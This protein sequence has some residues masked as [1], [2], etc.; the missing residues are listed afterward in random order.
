MGG[1]FMLKLIL[2]DRRC[3][4]TVAL[5]GFVTVA[6]RV[7]PTPDEGFRTVIAT[8]YWFM[9]ASVVLFGWAVAPLL[10]RGWQTAFGDRAGMG[11]LAAI[12]LI[13]T[14]WVT[15]EPPGYKVLADEVLLS[16]TAMG[17][18]Q[19]RKAAYPLRA[20]DLQGPLQILQHTMD[21]RPLLFPFL[22]ATVHDLT[23]YRP[24]NA[25]HLNI[26]LAAVFLALVFSLGRAAGGSVWAGALML[27][28]FGGL[29]LL[30]QQA[31]GAGMELLNLALLSSTALLVA[32]YLRQPNERRLQALVFGGLLLA[33]TRYES[34]IVM[35]PIAG[36]VFWGW[37]RAGRIILPW[38]VVL[39]PLFLVPLLLQN[40][41]FSAQERTWEMMSQPGVTSPLGVQYLADNLGHALAFL[42]DFSGYQTSSPVFA[43]LG[44]IA[45]PFFALWSMRVWRAGR[46]ADPTDLAWTITGVALFAITAVHLLYFLGRY[47]EPVIRRLSLPLHLLMALAIVVVVPRLFASARAWQVAIVLAL[48][49]MVFHSLPVMAKRAYAADY[50]PGVEMQF[51]RDFLRQL[52][53]RDFLFIDQDS[54]FWIVHKV[55]ASSVARAQQNRVGLIY[56][57]RNQSFSAMFV[58]QSVLVDGETGRQQIDP[59]D[60]L[61]PDFELEPVLERRIHAL[62]FARI[63]RIKSIRDGGAVAAR[64]ED[65]LPLR[66]G[67]RLT[68]AELDRARALYLERW[69]K[70]LP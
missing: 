62:L 35:L 67:D 15:H 42:F 38:S 68:R 22:T 28:L 54:V 26:A 51:R 17:M 24:E 20:T 57:L 49:G 19:D 12:A 29:P 65:G 13:L 16:G 36:A 25:F 66:Q 30:A 31:T 45:L 11:A 59:A 58:F 46:G 23:G 1:F 34:V 55:A 10:R 9:F 43:A 47:D 3:W 52:P 8:G 33:S 18:H 63:S 4:A 70:Q 37:S 44:L 48:G 7:W 14:V 60:D 6:T 64:A 50:T 27:V 39:T 40:R 53:V 21:K 69:V 41:L 5:L 61:G 2:T 56:H 32:A